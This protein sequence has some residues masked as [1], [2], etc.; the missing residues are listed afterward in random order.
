VR[1]NADWLTALRGEGEEQAAALK[2]LLS[3]LFRAIRKQLGESA[4]RADGATI[5][6][7]AEDYTQDAV[8]LVLS[9]LDSFRGESRFTTWVYTIALRLVLADLRRR[10]WQEVSLDRDTGSDEVPAWPLQDRSPDPEQTLQQDH[11]WGTIRTAIE[12][13]LT[14]RQR[15]VL[16]AAAFDGV[17]LDV[18]AERLGT[19]RDNIY[20]ILHDARRHLKRCLAARNLSP[21]EILAVFQGPG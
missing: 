13:E 18:L 5:D 21:A 14:A 12:R 6:P 8:M 10:R 3:L 7:R 19:T 20:K 15:T 16:V 1:S 4:W 9:K 2:D 11:L 17:P